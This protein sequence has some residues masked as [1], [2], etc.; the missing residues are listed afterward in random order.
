[1]LRSQ[2]L[3]TLLRRHAWSV[4]QM[5]SSQV[6]AIIG[7][8]ELLVEAARRVPDRSVG[9][10]HAAVVLLDGAVEAAISVC[11]GQFG[12]SAGERDTL[13]D[14]HR[15][16]AKQ[17]SVSGGTLRGWRDANRLRRARNL[18][19]HHQIP[20]DSDALQRLYPPV[21]EYV[22]DAIRGT[23]GVR[24]VDVVLG[25]AIADE[26]LR[27][28]LV[29]AE[30]DLDGGALPAGLE[31]IRDAFTTAQQR[32]I[33]SARVHSGGTRWHGSDDLGVG[34]M[35]DDRTAD[36]RDL[37]EALP[38]AADAAEYIWYR[39]LTSAARRG[40]SDAAT[41][42][43][44]R[45]A[46]QFVVGWIVRWEAYDRAHREMSERE[47][48]RLRVKAPPST[49]AGGRP[50]WLHAP[51][52]TVLPER[53]EIRG[54]VRWGEPDDGDEVSEEW[55]TALGRALRRLANVDD[56]YPGLSRNQVSLVWSPRERRSPSAPPEGVE[57]VRRM[58]S[59]LR[60]AFD[61]TPTEVESVRAERTAANADLLRRE[62]LATRLLVEIQGSTGGEASPF[63]SASTP[64][65]GGGVD[66]DLGGYEQ[67]ELAEF[68]RRRSDLPL[69][70]LVLRGDGHVVWHIPA[71][72]DEGLLGEATRRV[73]SVMGD[74]VAQCRLERQAAAE[75]Q[76]A[77][78]DLVEE[79]WRD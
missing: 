19:Q 76:R 50:E 77:A 73:V 10:R 12:D 13:A 52:V 26:Q 44:A 66:V 3:S 68:W 18:A 14:L 67:D 55:A 17:L 42:G 20:V 43:D 65:F 59:V 35:I 54:S 72:V 74:A 27:R 7:V 6:S 30:G 64:D 29:E 46:L 47:R 61:E 37:V 33:S 79:V 60:Q 69:G 9:G 63:K 16:L 48:T 5:D 39:R 4:T 2:Q 28:V 71:A 15:R 23:F 57:R 78:S 75:L 41:D 36:I 70:N 58:M 45:R 24:L 49:R 56:M 22:E 34:R 62:Q 21:P 8:R 40:T 32:W 1:V 31:K 53:V 51:E 38:F 11:L 25:D